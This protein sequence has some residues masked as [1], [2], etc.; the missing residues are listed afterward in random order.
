MP[1][2]MEKDVGSLLQADRKFVTEAVIQCSENEEQESHS[3]KLI[4][5][6]DMLLVAKVILEKKKN[7]FKVRRLI[8]LKEV[9][10]LLKSSSVG[11]FTLSRI[12]L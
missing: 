6:N 9:T 1:K 2:K 7:I 4:L 11:E 5:F 12:Y 3:R 10:N 8:Y